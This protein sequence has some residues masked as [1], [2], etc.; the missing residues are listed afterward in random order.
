MRGRRELVVIR[1]FQFR[2][3]CYMHVLDSVLCSSRVCTELDSSSVNCSK[4]LLFCWRV[5][6][7]TAAGTPFG[8]RSCCLQSNSCTKG[9]H[10]HVWRCVLVDAWRG[11]ALATVRRR[12]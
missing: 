2:C 4:G 9:Y 6:P 10:H 5:G 3:S 7:L 1:D 11:F 8:P 12:L